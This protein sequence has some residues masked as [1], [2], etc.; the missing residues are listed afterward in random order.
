MNISKLSLVP[1]QHASLCMDCEMI[2]AAHTHCCACG[3]VALLNLARTLNGGEDFT[4]EPRAFAA[5]ANIS[6]AR[7]FE[8]R[9][10]AASRP[11]PHTGECVPFPQISA[12]I[13]V[14]AGDFHSPYSLRKV[15]TTVQ[16][17]MTIA[18]VG[19]LALGA[20]IEAHGG[21]VDI[22]NTGNAVNQIYSHL[23]R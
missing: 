17:A 3:S 20:A 14:E 8:P 16:R 4:P 1:L 6:D 15:A 2:T 9:A 23:R 5:V 18:I 11:R 19:I 21:S 12:E 10:G 13:A 7:S 22:A